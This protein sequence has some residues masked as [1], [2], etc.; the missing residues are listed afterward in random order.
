MLKILIWHVTNSTY[1][2][3]R[4]LKIL[5]QQHDGIEIVGEAVNEEIAK[6]DWGDYDVLL[7]AGTKVK[8]IRFSEVMKDAAQLNLPEEKMLGDWIVCLPGFTLE[9]YRLLQRSNLSIISRSCFGGLISNLLG[10]QFLSP[11]VNLWMNPKDFICFLRHP[12]DYMEEELI[13][14]EKKYRESYGFDIATFTC[15]NVSIVMEHYCDFNEAVDLWNERKKRINWNNLL[16]VTITEDPEILREF[17]ALPYEKKI[18]FV[19]FKSDLDSAWYINPET[20]KDTKKLWDIVHLSVLGMKLY[21]DPFDML[22]YG[23]KT[24]L[25]DM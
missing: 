12:H 10:L 13:F 8:G 24:P 16:V 5:E 1:F 4:A 19:S 20:R 2:Q 23:K 9:K 22:L 25:I 3:K 14:K 11:F 21:Y 7:V 6:V 18:C 15:G 17:D